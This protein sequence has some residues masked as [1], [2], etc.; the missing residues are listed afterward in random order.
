MPIEKLGISREMIHFNYAVSQLPF[1]YI[2]TEPF[3]AKELTESL[4]KHTQARLR[5]YTGK[6]YPEFKVNDIIYIKSVAPPGTNKTF[7]VPSQGPLKIVHV[8]QRRKTVRN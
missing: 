4:Q 8:H 6:Q 2:E 5:N 7:F 3:S 1:I